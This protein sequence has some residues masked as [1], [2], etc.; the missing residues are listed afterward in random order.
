MSIVIWKSL[1]ALCCQ[2]IQFQ[3][4]WYFCLLQNI[5]YG[6]NGN[7]LDVYF[8]MEE[9]VKKDAA[10]SEFRRPVVVFIYGGSWGSGDK[11][12]YGLLASQLADNLSAVVICPNYSIYPKVSIQQ[13]TTTFRQHLK[14]FLF[15]R[16]FSL[17]TPF[18][19][20][21]ALPVYLV[22]SALE[23]TAVTVTL[24]IN[25]CCHCYSYY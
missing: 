6:S 1:F 3:M 18:W 10:Q 24:T 4:H 15:Q 21:N 22:G 2:Q 9:T 8:P 25:N 12:M 17:E 19:L 5:A 7:C 16:A 11:S 20:C 13:S 23:I 14:T